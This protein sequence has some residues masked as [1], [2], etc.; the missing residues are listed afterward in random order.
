[1]LLSR[2]ADNL[3]WGSR[4]LER[5]EDT[6]RI[7][8]TYTE[9]LLDL[10]IGL[11]STWEPLL[12]IAGSRDEFDRGHVRASESDVVRFLVADPKNLGSVVA[13]VAQARE[14]LRTTREVMPRE[15][16]QSVNDLYLFTGRD[17]ELGVD[18]RSRARFLGKVIDEIQHLEGVLSGSMLRDEAHELWR[19]GQLIE[20]AEMTTRVIGVRAAALFTA[21]DTADFPEV[22]W[23]GVL[24]AVTGLQ[25]YQRTTRGPIDGAGVVRFLLFDEQFPRSVSGCLVRIRAALVRLPRPE[26]TMAAATEV[27]RALSSTVE[28]ADDGAELDDAMDRVQRTLA[29]LHD[30][31]QATFVHTEE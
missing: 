20:R 19:L 18:R 25:M 1:M 5:A 15:A 21:E 28:V 17:G 24:R 27:E 11:A 7:V 8:R 30:A 29:H 6:A 26:R 4:Y 2:V 22:Q 13:S 9:V 12:A 10:P 31:V 23:M 3:Y 16:W 14:N